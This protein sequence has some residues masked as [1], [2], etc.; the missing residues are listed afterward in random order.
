M[1][2]LTAALT[3]WAESFANGAV[4][5]D[6]LARTRLRALSGH[7]V[8]IEIYPP[9]ETIRLHFDG[10]SIRLGDGAPE[11]APSVRVRGS[12]G[13]LAA[14]LFDLDGANTKLD[15]DGDHTILGE[16]RAIVRSFRPDAIPPLQ[17][18]VGD[19][20]AQTITNLLEVGVSALAALG[21]GARDE[22]SRL[23]RGTIGQ[24]Y[25]TAPELDAYLHASQQLRI[26]V[27]RLAVRIGLVEAARS[28]GRE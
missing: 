20:A 18:L 26:R 15:I 12:A 11:R 17:E 4:Q 22:G 25:L 21:R 28:T 7:V 9:G 3:R 24:R 23:A 8:E 6:P 5:L 16:L 13:A 2:P 14:M 19:R 27:D 1:T 10:E